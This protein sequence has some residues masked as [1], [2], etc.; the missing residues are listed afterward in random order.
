[1]YGF[2]TTG[3][4]H[5]LKKLIKSHQTT[6]FYL[7]KYA[8]T[9]LVYYEHTKKRSIFVSGKTFKIIKQYGQLE[10]SGFVSMHHVPVMDDVKTIFEEKMVAPFQQMET[11]NGVTSIRFLQPTKG[12]TY[13]IF[14]VW[15]SEKAFQQWTREKIDFSSIVRQP[16][17]FGERAFTQTY[18]MLK[19]DDEAIE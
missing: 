5:F 3:T 8:G 15:N 10:Q 1:M 16:A 11:T 7:M 12:N 6:T 17:Y 18:R 9:T 4:T 13:V 2:M 19:E 14:I